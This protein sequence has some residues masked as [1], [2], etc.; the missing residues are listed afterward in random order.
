MIQY[1]ERLH[2]DIVFDR[3]RRLE[4][5]RSQLPDF[6]TEKGNPKNEKGVRHVEIA[7]PS[8]FLK[9]GIALVDTPGV[10]SLFLHNT[11]TTREFIPNVD[12]AIF[13]LSADPPIT[14]SEFEFLDAVAGQ[15]E[16]IFFLFNKADLLTAAELEETL[17]YT[18]D[19]IRGTLKIDPFMLLPISS[20]Q[21]L[22]GRQTTDIQLLEQSG[23]ENIERL[24]ASFLNNERIS[25]LYRRSE[26]RLRTL[27]SEIRYALQ[28]Q[29]KTLTTPSV[30]LEARIVE[31]NADIL[32][33]LKDR[34]QTS[35]ILS[36]EM[37]KLVGLIDEALEKFSK[38]E[39][40]ELVSKLRLWEGDQNV[41]HH[42]VF[43]E[44][45]QNQLLK[46][47]M[48][49]F[50]NWRRDFE[51]RLISEYNSVLTE[52]AAKLN[53][54]IEKIYRLSSSLFDVSIHH[55][56]TVDPV[57]WKGKFY[58]KVEREPLFLE[59]DFLRLL[60]PILRKSF[61]RRRMLRRVMSSVDEIVSSHCGRL[62]YE[63]VY[64]IEEHY[65]LFQAELEERF[66][67]L[68]K[69]TQ[70]ILQ[71][72]ASLKTQQEL[73]VSAIVDLLRQQLSRLDSLDKKQQI[74]A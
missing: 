62:R 23:I 50:A 57:R 27:A 53:G 74:S 49:D 66:D 47:L 11:E 26:K 43:S 63:Y 39:S 35:Y 10:G 44:Q 42:R 17:S 68:V 8:Q 46:Q 22:K 64:S 31:F 20:R 7:F 13:V 65:R 32:I 69:E 5:H 40:Q 71:K 48:V 2:I 30:D 19:V 25:V 59:V 15:V 52:C 12:A 18:D 37:K 51:P 54:C 45:I 73:V 1:G 33:I 41:L 67:G 16:R 61:F 28:L 70:A 24:V 4:V 36:G 60:A 29:L 56:L 34:E 14:Q 72:A 9:D 6:I 58:H 3:N 55:E 38:T 21:A